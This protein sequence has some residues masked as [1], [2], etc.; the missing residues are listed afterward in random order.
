MAGEL[1]EFNHSGS[2]SAQYGLQVPVLNNGF[3]GVGRLPDVVQPWIF[4]LKIFASRRTDH[5]PPQPVSF[6]SDH[7]QRSF[8]TPYQN[9]KGR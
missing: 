5:H 2:G 3:Y 4:N 7:G 6:V 9:L 8:P 1:L